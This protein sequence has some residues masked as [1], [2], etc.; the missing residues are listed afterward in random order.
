MSKEVIK[1]WVAT[2]RSGEYMQGQEYLRCK[3]QDANE[4]DKFCCLGVLCD[5]YD[6]QAWEA[7]RFGAVYSYDG[8]QKGVPA[9]DIPQ[10]SVL[11]W[12]GIDADDANVLAGMNDEGMDFSGIADYIERTHLQN[13]TN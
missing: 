13:T 10:Q 11:D 5:M 2:L 6:S 12:A 4:P 8:D 9:M 3:D 1:N 7:S